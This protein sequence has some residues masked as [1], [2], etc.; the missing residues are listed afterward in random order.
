MATATTHDTPNLLDED[1]VSPADGVE[2]LTGERPSP[3]TC[4]RWISKGLRAHK[5][6]SV[7]VLGRTFTSHQAIRRWLTKVEESRTAAQAATR[8][9]G[10]G[11]RSE[12][13][14]RRLEAA[15]L[16]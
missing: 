13:L 11:E 9:D 4:W 7:K 16:A 5:L 12:D 15:G 8:D 1:L 2:E 3:T 10:T 6:E 14:Q